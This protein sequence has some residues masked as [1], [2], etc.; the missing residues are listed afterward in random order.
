MTREGCS[1][2]IQIVH[3]MANNVDSMFKTAPLCN[4]TTDAII[5]TIVV[6]LVY[7]FDASKTRKIVLIASK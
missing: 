1:T 2:G 7:M 4:Y 5:D 3:S 6:L